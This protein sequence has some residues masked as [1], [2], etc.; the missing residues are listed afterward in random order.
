MLIQSPVP[1]GIILTDALK[2]LDKYLSD[3]YS[4]R[5]DGTMPH[6]PDDE[7]RQE[8]RGKVSEYKVNLILFNDALEA[9]IAKTAQENRD[10]VERMTSKDREGLNPTNKPLAK[11]A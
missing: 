8:Y 7:G 4:Y 3:N 2:D 9:L 5:P 1:I 6:I 11:W 10:T